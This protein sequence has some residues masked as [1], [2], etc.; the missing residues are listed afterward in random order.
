MEWWKSGYAG[1]FCA[2]LKRN[3][4]AQIL[5]PKFPI[6]RRKKHVFKSNQIQFF[7]KGINIHHGWRFKYYYN[8]NYASISCDRSKNSPVG[9]LSSVKIP[10]SQRI[11]A[12]DTILRRYIFDLRSSIFVRS[13]GTAQAQHST[14]TAQHRHSNPILLLTTHGI[15]HCWYY[16]GGPV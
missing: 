11:P 3:S 10:L 15:F 14:G 7:H 12:Y 9:N 13:T 8:Y 16:P 5:K 4:Q 2:I 6:L 1:F